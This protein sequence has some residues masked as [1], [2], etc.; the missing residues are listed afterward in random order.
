MSDRLL[1]VEAPVWLNMKRLVFAAGS[2]CEREKLGRMFLSSSEP[3]RFMLL[4]LL[5]NAQQDE[6]AASC[7]H[8][9]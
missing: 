9:D 4:C 5:A 3:E 6:K 1:A 2:R 8:S 7:L